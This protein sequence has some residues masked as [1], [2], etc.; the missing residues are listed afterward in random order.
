[1]MIDDLKAHLEAGATLAG[2]LYAAAG[3]TKIF[4]ID[5]EAGETSPWVRL[6][7]S[8]DGS[9]DDTIDEAIFNVEIVAETYALALQI[10]EAIDDL[11]DLQDDVAIASSA[12]KVFYAK[13]IAGGSDRREE[14]TRLFHVARLYRVKSRKL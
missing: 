10:L 13:K 1:M 9:E 7:Y 14:D 2:L 5:E 6:S 4:T 11:L 12:R 8:T 3:N